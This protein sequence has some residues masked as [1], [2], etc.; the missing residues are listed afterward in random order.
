MKK[1]KF[2]PIEAHRWFAVEI[3]NQAWDLLES[4]T[5][6]EEDDELLRNTAHA[7]CRLK[8][9][10]SSRQFVSAADAPR[11]GNHLSQPTHR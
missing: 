7:A 11:G 5:R 8:G 6:T 3:N 4:D 9:L 1:P 2:D 10:R